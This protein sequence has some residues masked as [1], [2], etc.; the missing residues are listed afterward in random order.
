MCQRY[1]FHDSRGRGSV[2]PLE[3]G[4]GTRGL[5]KDLG[6]HYSAGGYQ[7]ND[8]WATESSNCCELLRISSAEGR[9]RSKKCGV[10]VLYS[11]HRSPNL[12][13]AAVEDDE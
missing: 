11:G 10:W 13:Q 8:R 6:T 12:R 2:L 5:L 7:V 3:H 1:L 4:L 9:V